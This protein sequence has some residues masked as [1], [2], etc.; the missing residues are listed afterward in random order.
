MVKC[1]SHRKT[2]RRGLKNACSSK[3]NGW[4]NRKGGVTANGGT[5]KTHSWTGISRNGAFGARSGF[6]YSIAETRLF[7]TYQN[8]FGYISD[9]HTYQCAP[10]LCLEAV[11]DRTPPP[12]HP[13][14]DSYR[15]AAST[16]GKGKTT[17][18][19]QQKTFSKMIS[20]NAKNLESVLL[21][22]SHFA[23]MFSCRTL[24]HSAKVS[25]RTLQITEPKAVNS[26]KEYHA[27]A[28]NA[29]SFRKCPPTAVVT[30]SGRYRHIVSSMVGSFRKPYWEMP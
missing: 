1:Y 29:G 18:K 28:W 6:P 27:E 26:E 14:Y 23:V 11:P 8:R 24:T 13:P 12:R 7:D 15:M 22:E 19:T 17:P 21:A 4:N 5:A 16:C 9:Y 25:C 3:E 20:L 30:Y 2:L 10:A